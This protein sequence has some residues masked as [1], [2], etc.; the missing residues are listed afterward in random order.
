MVTMLGVRYL[1]LLRQGHISVRTS[2]FTLG[3]VTLIVEIRIELRQL[4]NLQRIQE[5]LKLLLV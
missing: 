3:K 1:R 4:K 2:Y 5:P